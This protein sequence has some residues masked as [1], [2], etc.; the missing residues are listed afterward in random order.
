MRK[1]DPEKVRQQR[2]LILRAALKCFAKKG[3]HGTS[4]DDIC[5]AAKISSGTLYYYFK[6]RDRLLHDV[7]VHAHAT[8]DRLLVDMKD[9]SDLVDAMMTAQTASA[10]AAKA[11]GVPM[12]VL[13]ELLAYA[14]HNAT[15][16]AAFQDATARMMVYMT[17]A[18][19]AHQQAG[20]LP[21]DIPAESLGRAISS[22]AAGYSLLEISDRDFSRASYR[23]AITALLYRGANQPAEALPARVAQRTRKGARAV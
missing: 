11:Q 2:E 17:E 22:I 8:R 21:A 19:R 23:D 5:R 16:K 14:Q 20:K 9:A 12:H 3:V 18:T 15:A 13:L 6:S 4:T 10:E 1:T 7:I